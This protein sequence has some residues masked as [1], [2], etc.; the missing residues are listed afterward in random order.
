MRALDEDG[1]EVARTESD[2]DGFYRLLL[3]PGRYTLAASHP[4]EGSGT[5]EVEV[6]WGH[7]LVGV[8]IVL[9]KS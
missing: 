4:R 7:I 9:H 6:P 1:A 8:D 2:E 5:R 3:R